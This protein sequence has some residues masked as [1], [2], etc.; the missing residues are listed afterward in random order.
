MQRAG[1]A[2]DGKYQ[3]G[4]VGGVG[5]IE[6]L[7]PNGADDLAVYEQDV[8]QYGKQIGLQRADDATIDKGFT[9]RSRR[10]TLIS[11]S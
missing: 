2:Q 6:M 1:V 9:P 5:Q 10:R 7:M 8:P 4:D 3:I 11:K